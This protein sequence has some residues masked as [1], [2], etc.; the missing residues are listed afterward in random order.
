MKDQLE[1]S[2]N[3][4]AA[5]HGD[6]D[7]SGNRLG[8]SGKVSDLF[9]STSICAAG[10]VECRRS[11]IT[12]STVAGVAGQA[13]AFIALASLDFDGF[14]YRSLENQGEGTKTQGQQRGYG[15]WI[16]NKH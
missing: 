12:P 2:S 16:G 1:T 9:T 10:K 15:T 13:L 3:S 5:F 4:Q 6:M 11:K 7:K 8:S 14:W